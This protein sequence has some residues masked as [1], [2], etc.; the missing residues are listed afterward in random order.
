MIIKVKRLERLLKKEGFIRRTKPSSHIT[1]DGLTLMVERRLSLVT[2]VM[3]F[4]GN[5]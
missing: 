5:F 1:V 4:M 3:K 2:A